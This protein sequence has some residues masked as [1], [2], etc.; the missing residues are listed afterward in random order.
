MNFKFDNNLLKTNAGLQELNVFL[1]NKLKQIIRFKW[2]EVLQNL[3]SIRNKYKLVL[4]SNQLNNTNHIFFISKLTLKPE[5]IKKFQNEDDPASC[6]IDFMI[7][8]CIKLKELYETFELLKL[9][10][11]LIFF[12]KQITAIN[13]IQRPNQTINIKNGEDLNVSCYAECF[14]MP[15]YEYF[16][17]AVK[18]YDGPNLKKNALK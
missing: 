16:K 7:V 14:P 12:N 15:T 1:L 8:K 4:F 17:N 5:T 11:G 3:E 18:I 10:E 9:E 13:I 2:L 6:A